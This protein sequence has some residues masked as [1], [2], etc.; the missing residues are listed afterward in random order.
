VRAVLFDLYDTLIWTEWPL[1][2]DRLAETIGRST[3]DVMRGFIETRDA[4]G[5]GAFGSAEGDIAAVLRAAGGEPTDEE[6]RR[7]TEL[8]NRALAEGGMH[9]YEDSLPVLRELRRRGIPTAIVSNCDHWTRPVV[10]ALG[11]EAEVDATILSFEVRVMKPD[12]EIYRIALGRIGAEPE[13][14][15]F[16]DDQ[17]GYLD[18]AAALGMTTVQIARPTDPSVPPRGDHPVIEDLWAVVSDD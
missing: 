3:R 12:P 13:T 18:G 14:S 4:R 10:D 5:V 16:V 6:V 9:L 8:E 11:L 1:L 2:R 17:P 15:T 7:L